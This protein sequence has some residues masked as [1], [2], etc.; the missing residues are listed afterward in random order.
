MHYTT[1][2]SLTEICLTCFWRSPRMETPEFSRNSLFFTVRNNFLVCNMNL[3]HW[4]FIPLPPVSSNMGT[5]NKFIPFKQQPFTCA[6]CSHVP[7][8]SF[9]LQAEQVNYPLSFLSDCFPDLI[10]SSVSLGL[11][12]TSLKF[13]LRAAPSAVLQLKFH[14]CCV[15]WRD[16][17]A[18]AADYISIY[19]PQYDV[20][21]FYSSMMLLTHFQLVIHSNCQI[22]FFFYPEFLISHLLSSTCAADC[23]YLTTVNYPHLLWIILYFCWTAPLICHD[24]FEFYLSVY[25]HVCKCGKPTLCSITHTNRDSTVLQWALGIP[26]GTVYDA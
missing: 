22:L 15:G 10:Q 19:S 4:N 5:K 8:Q 1:A 26:Y 25:C 17:P 20:S 13:S 11:L 18:S 3:S 24:H 14:Q 2:I 16:D 6:G 21:L 9:L 23:P 12:L 7:S